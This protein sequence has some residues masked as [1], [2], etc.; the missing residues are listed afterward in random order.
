MARTA[1]KVYYLARYRLVRARRARPRAAARRPKRG[2]ERLAYADPKP[3]VSL[4]K[5]LVMPG[6]NLDDGA[7]MHIVNVLFR[8][9]IWVL[10]T[11][12][13]NSENLC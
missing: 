4:T 2:D 1:R 12:S 11:S 8:A 10:S 9:Q 7:K 6:W 5:Y 13:L 3:N